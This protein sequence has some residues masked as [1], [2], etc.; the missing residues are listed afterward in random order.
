MLQLEHLLQHTGREL[1]AVRSAARLAQPEYDWIAAKGMCAEVE[2]LI[3][4][5]TSML[6]KLM[7]R[8]PDPHPIVSFVCGPK[9]VVVHTVELYLRVRWYSR[10]RKRLRWTRRARL[11]TQRWEK[12]TNM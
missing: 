4:E 12:S 7:L 2:E 10:R 5:A 1:D 8:K 9:L 3:T 6:H 11:Q